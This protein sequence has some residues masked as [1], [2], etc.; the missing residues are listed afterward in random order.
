MPA[1]P[2]ILKDARPLHLL[3][4]HAQRGFNLVALGEVHFNHSVA[5]Y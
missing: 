2:Q 4:E 5:P 3:L 1:A